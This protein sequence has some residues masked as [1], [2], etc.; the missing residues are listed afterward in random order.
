MKRF[1]LG[2]YETLRLVEGCSKGDLW[3]LLGLQHAERTEAAVQEAADRRYEAL[4]PTLFASE[5][6]RAR[7]LDAWRRVELAYRTLADGH[8]RRLYV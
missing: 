8:L 7:A 6:D 3:G 5:D 2:A 4:R 1:R